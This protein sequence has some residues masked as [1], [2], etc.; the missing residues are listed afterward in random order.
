MTFCRMYLSPIAK[1]AGR[2]SFNDLLGTDRKLL[3]PKSSSIIEG[4]GDCRGND[5]DPAS[6]TAL[7]ENGPGPTA[8]VTKALIRGG[9]SRTQ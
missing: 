5:A 2:Y 9:T 6:P 4:I 1:S 8:N 3:D 7:A